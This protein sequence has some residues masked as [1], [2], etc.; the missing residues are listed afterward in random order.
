M[1]RCLF[2]LGWY[3]T[4]ADGRQE[5]PCECGAMVCE[6]DQRDVFDAETSALAHAAIDNA[7]AECNE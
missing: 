7:V 4:Q 6:Q 1:P 3:V 2:C 5:Q